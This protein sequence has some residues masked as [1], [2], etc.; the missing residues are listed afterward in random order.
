MEGLTLSQIKQMGGQPTVA[1]IIPTSST[2]PQIGGLTLSQLKQMGGVPSSEMPASP[3][4]PN[5]AQ[6]VGDEF[7]NA[8]TQGQ[9]LVS[10]SLQGVLDTWQKDW[11][12]IV[13]RTKDVL[14]P[15]SAL[16]TT[17]SPTS[18]A[19]SAAHAAGDVGEMA[20]APFGALINVLTSGK[21][22][23]LINATGGA[24]GSTPAAQTAAAF[25]DQH[26]D[27]TRFL[28]Q[29]VPNILN[30]LGTGA[31]I[32]DI[33]SPGVNPTIPKTPEMVGPTTQV[34]AEVPPTETPVPATNPI[35]EQ[36][37]NSLQ[38]IENGSAPLR[39]IVANATQQ[40]VDVK[41]LV[42]NTDL[43]QGSVDDTGTI[44]TK[45]P[46][47]A[48]SQ[49]N[50][51]MSQYES[52]VSD[53]LAKEGKTIPLSDV[54]TA[55]DQALK[56]SRIAGSGKI[57]LTNLFNNEI[58]GLKLDVDA[59]GNI[60]LSKLQDAKISTTNNIDYNNPST[61]INAKTVASIYRTLIENNS[62]LDVAGMNAELAKFYK[63]GDYLEALDGKKVAGG[64]LGKYFAQTV[65]AMAGSHFG[66]LGTI[67]GAEIAGKI[68]GFNLSSTFGP[69]IGS[70]LEAS[71]ALKNLVQDNASGK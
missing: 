11:G 17:G 54:Q 9:K 58:A 32:A 55:F 37:I 70:G 49:F 16:N 48:V 31:G 39:K 69:E 12:D 67:I 3:T 61:K 53:G 34:P 25:A 2:T 59:D 10:S 43:L 6:Q 15:S 64:K 38:Q 1:P 18:G 23:E 66:P 33:V 24:I 41:S 21:L 52:A 4:Q 22:G 57:A 36:R 30:G 62:D 56:N 40:G 47:E 44:M 26:P 51:F 46:G 68:K 63:I 42:S 13:N 28:L 35:V 20:S 27:A 29:D 8:T 60:S 50:Q 71:G 19:M 45:G 65:G 14:N 5:G 7:Q